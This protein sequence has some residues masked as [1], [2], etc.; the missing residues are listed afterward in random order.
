MTSQKIKE[1]KKILIKAGYEK[2]I[3][4]IFFMEDFDFN[5]EPIDFTFE[6]I[7]FTF[8]PFDLNL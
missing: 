3:K 5:I 4:D 7:D 6:S 1:I 8:E 2:E